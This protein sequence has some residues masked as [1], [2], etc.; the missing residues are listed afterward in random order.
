MKYISHGK[1]VCA[2]VLVVASVGISL[3]APSLV[4]AA[5]AVPT[6]EQQVMALTAEVARLSA[7]HTTTV[8]PPPLTSLMLASI[9]RNAVSWLLAAQEPSGHFRYEYV[10]YEDRYLD[11]DNIVRQAG[12]LYGLGEALH[13]G[14]GN[15]E[16]IT[17]AMKRSIRYFESLS[18]EGKVGTVTFRCVADSATS[19]RCKLGATALALTGILRLAESDAGA[20][21]EYAPLISSYAAFV[22]AMQKDTGGFQGTFRTTTGAT[23]SIA[24]SSYSTGEALLAL[25]RYD[26]Y[27][28][29]PTLKARIDKTFSYIM[30]SVPFDSALYLWA[31][32]ALADWYP[33][34][35]RAEYVSYTQAYTDWR[36]NGFVAQRGTGHNMCAYT[37][38]LALAYSVLD[39]VLS[40]SVLARYTDEMLFW[41]A[42]ERMLQVGVTDKTR[43]VFASGR[44][45]FVTIVNPARAYGGFLTGN[46]ALTQRID[47]TQHC[48]TTY[49][50]WNSLQE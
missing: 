45:S 39:N 2:Q 12:A 25:V 8:T 19:T 37:E 1:Q 30:S 23:Q 36:M 10:P 44:P 9:T 21:R 3:S 20:A 43:V 38:G 47:F 7:R 50:V 6:L 15:A 17:A 26:A 41:L 42:K 29:D 48:L 33:Q 40:P 18:P 14:A 13:H 5:S 35:P 46:T 49:L 32:A 22:T 11:D 4:R 27:R 34:K 31:M 16:D 24:E 28:P